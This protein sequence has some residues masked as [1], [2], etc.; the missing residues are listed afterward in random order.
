MC[1]YPLS[2]PERN[3]QEIGDCPPFLACQ[4]ILASRMLLATGVCRDP[5]GLCLATL[6]RIARNEVAN[7]PGRIE[8]RVLKRRRHR[9]PLMRKGRKELKEEMRKT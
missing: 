9:Y 8:P 6:E 7:R 4:A 1:L 3:S 5:R 2:T